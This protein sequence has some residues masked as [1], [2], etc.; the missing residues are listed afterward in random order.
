[1]D[2]KNLSVE[3]PPSEFGPGY[4]AL[5]SHFA[6]VH[7]ECDSVIFVCLQVNPEGEPH[8]CRFT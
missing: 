2:F 1:M 5:T 8:S 3:Q 6:C 7:V 4:L